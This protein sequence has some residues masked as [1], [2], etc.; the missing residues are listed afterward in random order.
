MTAVHNASALEAASHKGEPA[1]GRLSSRGADVKRDRRRYHPGMLPIVPSTTPDLA[2]PAALAA[3]LRGVERRA[4][5]LAELQTGDPTLGDAALTRAMAA[6]RS[7]AVDAPMADWPRLFWS[8]LLEQPALRRAT[9]ARPPAFLPACSTPVRAALLLRVAAG[10]EEDVAAA[11]LG[12]TPARLRTAVARGLACGDGAADAAAWVRLQAEVQRRIRDLPT[13]R[14]LRLARMREAALVGPAERFFHRDRPHARWRLLAA[15]AAV[16][17]LALAATFWRTRDGDAPIR[18]APLPAA[19]EP[20]SRYAA[21]SG[22]IA[23]PDFELLADPGGARLARDAA[24]LAWYV[25]HATP[26]ADSV[27]PADTSPDSATPDGA[28]TGDAP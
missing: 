20:A 19:G 24:F 7:L 10:L 13:E 23:H 6:F 26:A 1:G 2:Q 16:V 25:G 9:R 14:S 12:V 17:V 8:G 28:E 15:A 3:F 11:V 27:A 22:L 5:V 18:I 21:T 4:A